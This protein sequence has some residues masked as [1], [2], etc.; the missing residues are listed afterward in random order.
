MGFCGCFN[1]LVMNMEVERKIGICPI[2]YNG[3]DAS[4]RVFERD[5]FQI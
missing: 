2:Q 1:Q 3:N 4:V 5:S